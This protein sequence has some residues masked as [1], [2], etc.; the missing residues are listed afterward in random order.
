MPATMP[1][2]INSDLWT[3]GIPI[4]EKG[5]RT[6]GVYAGLVILLRLSGKRDLAQLNTFDLVV[7]LILANVVQNAVI[8]NDNSL[9]GG[10]IGATFLVAL[11]AVV[12]R[13]FRRHDTAVRLFEGD[14]TVLVRDGKIQE[15]AIRRLG[16]RRADVD[17]AIRRQGADRIDQV[18]TAT[19]EP[20]GLLVVDLF[21]GEHDA[22]QADIQRIEAKLDRALARLEAP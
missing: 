18:S 16:L 6:F 9:A 3:M 4:L 7:L 22:T 17:V 5:F 19:L 13:L 21:E 11:N 15:D 10:L 1:A 8:G 2:T 20:G 12:V 14:P